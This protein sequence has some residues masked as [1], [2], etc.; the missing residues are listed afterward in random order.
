[1]KNW[2]IKI[3]I[4]NETCPYRE[5][6]FQDNIDCIPLYRICKLINKNCEKKNCLFKIKKK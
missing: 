1:M 2:K 3:E 4:T 6:I 5:I